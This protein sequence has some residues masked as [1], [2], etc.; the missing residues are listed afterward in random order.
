MAL[1]ICAGDCCS[2]AIDN[3]LIMTKSRSIRG[4]QCSRMSRVCDAVP[5]LSSSVREVMG[6]YHDRGTI[7]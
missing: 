1:V 2:I 4:Y 5:I 7:A 6:Y 3:R